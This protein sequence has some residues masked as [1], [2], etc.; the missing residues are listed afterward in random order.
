MPGYCK[1]DC[2]KFPLA[3]NFSV[4]RLCCEHVLNHISLRVSGDMKGMPSVAAKSEPSHTLLNSLSAMT[5]ALEV[6]ICKSIINTKEAKHFSRLLF[7]S[8]L[9][10]TILS[11][12]K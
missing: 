4:F 11:L 10:I 1:N 2:T 6:K 12:H 7:L 3:L 8:R 5:A 9:Q